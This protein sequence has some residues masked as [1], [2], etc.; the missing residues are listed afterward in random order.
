MEPR[1]A[2]AAALATF[3]VL[4]RMVLDG[5]KKSVPGRAGKSVLSHQLIAE[6]VLDKHTGL[7]LG[8]VVVLTFGAALAVRR[9]L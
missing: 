5:P 8:L 7:K 2:A 3:G 1:F 6:T 9:Y 4:F